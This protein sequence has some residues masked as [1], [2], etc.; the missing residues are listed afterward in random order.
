MLYNT[1]TCWTDTL[2][3]HPAACCAVLLPCPLPPTRR[4]VMCCQVSV[5]FMN[6]VGAQALLGWNADLAR[7]AL[8]VFH[9][10]TL[11]QLEE[12]GG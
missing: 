12:F 5:A 11:A 2:P 1:S 6:V 4:A 7:A 10:I 8:N 3:T 9:R